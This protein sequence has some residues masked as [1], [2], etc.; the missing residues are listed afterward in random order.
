MHLLCWPFRWPCGSQIRWYGAE[1]ITQY[2]R[3]RATLDATGRRKRVSI[4]P[5]LP[6]RTPWSFWRKKSSCGV[7]KSLFEASAKKARNRPSTQLIKVT[8]CV[9]RWNATIKAEELTYF[10]AIK[11]WERTQIVEVTNCQKGS[12]KSGRSRPPIAGKLFEAVNKTQH[13]H[14]RPTP[15]DGHSCVRL[16]QFI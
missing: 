1:R 8:S 6:R 5:V 15:S 7:V 16:G 11:H 13:N 9:E 2:G 4:C 14:P 10:L 3:S 12:L